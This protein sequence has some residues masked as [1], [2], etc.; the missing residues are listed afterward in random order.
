MSQ[1]VDPREDR[2]YSAQANTLRAGMA[3]IQGTRANQC[4]TTTTLNSANGLGIAK[5]GVVAADDPVQVQRSGIALAKAGGTV[6]A[7]KSQVL[8]TTAGTLQDYDATSIGTGVM[9]NC[10]GVAL[11]SVSS[12]A[13]FRLAIGFHIR[14]G[15]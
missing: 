2:I 7:G 9:A 13:M 12:G 3:V 6:T 11:D 10:W 4:N 15:T 1:D 5:N 8:A 14:P